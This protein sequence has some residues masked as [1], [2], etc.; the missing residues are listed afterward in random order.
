MR[1]ASYRA[2]GEIYAAATDVAVSASASIPARGAALMILV[3]YAS[4]R[5]LYSLRHFLGA[6]AEARSCVGHG[7]GR[8]H[9]R[10]PGN[11]P[12]EDRLAALRAIGLSLRDDATLPD[13][14][15]FAGGCLMRMAERAVR[16]QDASRAP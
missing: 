2:D 14:L 9:T 13:G 11:P 5:Q 12:P 1:S 3:G 15:R 4:P 6:D 8:H 10:K 7:T 16:L